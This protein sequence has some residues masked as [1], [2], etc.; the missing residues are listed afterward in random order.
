MFLPEV[1]RRGGTAESENGCE[2]V[3]EGHEEGAKFISKGPVILHVIIEQFESVSGGAEAVVCYYFEGTE[4][5]VGGGTGAVN[6]EHA[7]EI[8][9]YFSWANRVE[10]TDDVST[11]SCEF[12]L[13][14]LRKCCRRNV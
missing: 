10:S 13:W 11:R 14:R 3:S 12:V 4:V 6:Q 9:L 7:K 1:D 8:S 5:L 2:K